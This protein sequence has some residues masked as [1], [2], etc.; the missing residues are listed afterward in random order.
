MHPKSLLLTAFLLLS[1][2]ISATPI[3]QTLSP[4]PD[5]LKN[6]VDPNNDYGTYSPTPDYSSNIDNGGYDTGVVPS[7]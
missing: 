3:P 2:L 1:T 6:L 7:Y 4:L 5:N